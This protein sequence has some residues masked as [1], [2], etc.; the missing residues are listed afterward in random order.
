MK[1][2]LVGTGDRG[3]ELYGRVLGQSSSA[4]LVGLFDTNPRRSE[5]FCKELG[6]NIPIY[7]EFEKMITTSQCDR[8]V[9]TSPDWTHDDYIVRGLKLH[10][11]VV[12]EK[13]MAIDA[14]RIARIREA[15]RESGNQVIVT[16]NYRYNA[17]MTEIRRLL[18]RATVGAVTSVQF[19]WLLDTIHGADYFRRWHRYRKNSGSLWVHKASHHF[20]LLNWWLD[21]DP[22]SVYATASRR[23]YG[24]DRL[25]DHGRRCATCEKSDVCPYA[26]HWDHHPE[27]TELYRTNEDV[28]G[29]WRDRCVFDGDLDIWDTMA[30]LIEYEQGVHVN[31]SLYAYAPFE[32]FRVTFNGTEGRLECMIWESGWD[33]YT[34]AFEARSQ[35]RLPRDVD[36]AAIPD[37][38]NASST[39]QLFP[40]FGGQQTFVVPRQPGGHGGADDRMMGMLLDPTLPDPLRHRANS[41]AGALA[42][43]VGIAATESIDH[44]APVNIKELID[45]NLLGL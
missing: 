1:Y 5:A 44:K 10:C 39:I 45:D 28:D 11:D 14:Q 32:G 37:R 15:E 43:L 20:D 3:L 9:I 40:N 34:P 4:Q 16:F 24:D 13:P 22:V 26:V 29:Y 8:V 27:W 25:K 2:A 42:A 17:Y 19:D 41:K 38:A 30:A 23:V 33:Q 31:Y 21:R 36:H 35:T 6:H 7:D 12:V 18:A